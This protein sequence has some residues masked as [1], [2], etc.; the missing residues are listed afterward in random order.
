MSL[1]QMFHLKDIPSCCAPSVAEFLHQARHLCMKLKSQPHAFETMFLDGTDLLS[2]WMRYVNTTAAVFPIV[3][4]RPQ[5][6]SPWGIVIAP[7]LATLMQPIRLAPTIVDGLDH[8]MVARGLANIAAMLVVTSV[9]ALGP[10]PLLCRT[11]PIHVTQESLYSW[12]ASRP[13]R[14]QELLNAFSSSSFRWFLL[15]SFASAAAHV[16]GVTGGLSAACRCKM[17]GKASIGSMGYLGPL[18]EVCEDT[19][20]R[21]SIFL[22]N[23]WW[24]LQACYLVLPGEKVMNYLLQRRKERM[25]YRQREGLASSSSSS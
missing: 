4:E 8:S 10:L 12:L 9:L 19:L 18:W 24:G 11:S 1:K 7:I 23:L 22:E 14:Q 5:P 3:P 21:L 17:P 16:H 20:L 2:T 15:N 6:P 25:E 13:L